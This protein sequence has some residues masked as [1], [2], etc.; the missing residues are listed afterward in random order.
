MERVYGWCPDVPD[1]RDF[2]FAVN[3]EAKPLPSAINHKEKMPAIWDQGSLG[4][5]T[6]HA[7]SAIVEY[8]QRKVHPQWDYMPSR[9]FI[10]YNERVIEGTVRSDCGAMIR[11]GIKVVNQIGAP[12]EEL[13]PYDIKAFTKKPPVKAYKNASVHQALLYERIP[14]TLNALQ[15]VLANGH[16]F[17]FGIAVFE[18]F[19]T[20]EVA[21]TG[22]VPMP[23]A[24]EKMLG[25][26]AVCC[27]GYDNLD[28]TFLVRNSWGANWGLD[29]YF[30]IP[31]TYVLDN[32][33]A[34]DFWTI[35]KME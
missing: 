24:N 14:Q 11:T 12:K 10:Y 25:G 21:N 5:C 20:Q 31:Y 2:K 27:V 34:D 15:Q 13:W 19:E 8:E 23:K 9:L 26:H 1:F 30:K 4:S 29:G 16:L 28:Q 35:T 33:L 22:I 6:G 7:I 17:V 3:T 32:N 18:S